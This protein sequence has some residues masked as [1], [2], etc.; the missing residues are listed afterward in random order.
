[1]EETPI[2]KIM[3]A[4]C[5]LHNMILKDE[6]HAISPDYIP[7]PPVAPQ[8]S[9]ERLFEIQNPNVHEDLKMDLIDHIHRTF[10]PGI[11]R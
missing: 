8:P 6:D 9:D 1:M 4:C 2:R 10:I 3:Y 11:D 5:I 7:D